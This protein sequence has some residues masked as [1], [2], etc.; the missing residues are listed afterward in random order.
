MTH[1]KTAAGKSWRLLIVEKKIFL[2]C[3]DNPFLS[4]MQ[5]N[6]KINNLSMDVAD[7]V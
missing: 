6:M 7:S 2:R 1:A 4:L 5:G 3:I